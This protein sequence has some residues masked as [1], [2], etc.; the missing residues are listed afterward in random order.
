MLK[1]IVEL[2]QYR[3]G[4]AGAYLRSSNERRQ[5]IAAACAVQRDQEVLREDADFLL[6][7][8]HHTILAKAYRRVP[9]GLR[10][11]LARAGAQPHDKR[12]YSILARTL[13]SPSHARIVQAINQLPSIDLTRLCVL[14][15]LPPEVCTPGVVEAV[16]DVRTTKDA[17]ALIEL[18]V[19]SGVDRHALATAITAVSDKRQLGRLWDRWA[20][21]CVFLHSRCSPARGI[22]RSR[23]GLTSVRWSVDTETARCAIWSMC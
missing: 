4:F 12:F 7:A 18:L 14:R 5:V 13:N 1:T 21:R 11:A 16:D 19:I 20:A 23:M 17:V 8:R 9:T 10:G 2:D 6:N 3:P 15:M 22:T